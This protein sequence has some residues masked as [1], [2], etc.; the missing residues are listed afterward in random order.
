MRLDG[1]IVVVTGAGSGIGAATARRCAREGA[2]V[3]VTDVRADAGRETVADVTDEDGS[4]T[5][6]PLDVRQYD[7][8]ERVASA[9]EA[10]YGR[11]DALVNNAGVTQRTSFAAQS[12]ADRDH[13]FSVNFFGTWN[14]CNAV[15]P[16]LAATGGGSVVNVSSVGALH[17]FPDA[18]LYAASK[19]AVLAL[20][21]SLAGAYGDDGVRVNAVLPGRVETPL[22]DR[23]IK[24]GTDRAKLRA[25]HALKR[26]GRP[27]EVA[28][29][30]AFL[31]SND[32]S[33]VTGHGL[34]VD[35]GSSL[36]TD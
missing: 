2:T 27:S 9:V 12:E 30:I 18:E 3:V 34:V 15:I 32:A 20:T 28:D 23:S 33:F 8:F 7:E 17:G 22:L 25:D 35:G 4:A 24:K 5:F 6:Y 26:F 13:L 10:E 36:R 16:R 31:L 11:I 29:S 21:K 14:G 1:N 19:G